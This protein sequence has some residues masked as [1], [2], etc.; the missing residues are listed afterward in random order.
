[1][2]NLRFA[3]HAEPDNRA[4]AEKLERAQATRTRGEP[5]VP[6]TIGEELETNPFLR[7]GLPSLAERFPGASPVEVLAAVRLAKDTFR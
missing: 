5:T 4:A 3:V 1:V 6:S 7:C 2:Q